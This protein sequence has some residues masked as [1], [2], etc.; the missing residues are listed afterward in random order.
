MAGV[1][2][3]FRGKDQGVA[4]VIERL[5]R[6]AEAQEKKLRE[7]GAAARQ[8]GNDQKAM[9]REAQKVL[10]QIA[11]PQERYNK[12]IE[13]LTKLLQ[14][15][16][17]EQTQFARATQLAKSEMDAST[18]AIAAHQQKMRELSPEA[19]KA[20]AAEKELGDSAK[21]WLA[22]VATPQQ[23]YNTKVAE[24]NKLLAAGKLNQDQYGRAVALAR[25]EM[26]QAGKAGN[27]AFGPGALAM[28]QSFA[29]AFGMAGGLAGAIALA[30][31]E[32]ENLINVQQQAA[33]IS[34][35]IAQAQE[36]ALTNLGADTK[37]Q[38][39]K[40]IQRVK[41]M[42]RELGV[43]ERDVYIRAGEALSARGDQSEDAAMAAVRASFKYSPGDAMAGQAAAG[44]ALDIGRLTGGTAEQ[45]LGFLREIGKQSRVT[46]PRKVAQ[47]LPPAMQAAMATG[48]TQEEAG[49]LWAAL[50]HGMTDTTGERSRTTAISFATQLRDFLPEMK[51][52]DERLRAVQQDPQLREQFLEKTSFE[53][54]AKIPVEEIVSGG[55]LAQTMQQFED[56]LPGLDEA[57]R[58]FN[59]YVA[60]RRSAQLQRLADLDRRAKAS[61]EGL[62]MA[63]PVK[64]QLG[65]IRENFKDTLAQAGL[66]AIG[67]KLAGLT[68]DARG[69]GI[70]EFADELEKQRQ[71]L[72]R[73]EVKG[74]VVG[75]LGLEMAGAARMNGP[76]FRAPTEVEQDQAAVLGL[77]IDELRALAESN[78]QAQQVPQAPPQ[79][80]LLPGPAAGQAAKATPAAARAAQR[81]RDPNYMAPVK[82]MMDQY[83]KAGLLPKG[84][85]PTD[86]AAIGG[87]G[88]TGM[89]AGLLGGA[90]MGGMDAGPAPESDAML[91]F[92]RRAAERTAADLAHQQARVSAAKAKDAGPAPES[93]AMMD[94]HRRA[95]DRTATDLAQ[96][97]DRVERARFQRLKD[98]AMPDLAEFGA[99]LPAAPNQANR[100][101]SPVAESPFA[102]PEGWGEASPAEAPSWGGLD[103][104]KMGRSVRPTAAAGLSPEMQDFA[105]KGGGMSSSPRTAATVEAPAAAQPTINVNVDNKE[106]R[107]LVDAMIDRMDRLIAGN[108]QRLDQLADKFAQ[109]QRRPTLVPPGMDR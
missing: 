13:H 95:A 52:F 83:E 17:L 41:D 8:S 39:D 31:A 65:V 50:T 72:E 103:I 4:A 57:E 47:S 9:G 14:A 66:P 10:D 42:A 106:L 105:S 2:L 45:S 61:V 78:K 11:T 36:T 85:A 64:A 76:V 81:A 15:G 25:S 44:A 63:D 94:F 40:F 6:L 67:Q 35:P 77:L 79:V 99:R 92:H 23:Q 60:D 53:Q 38:Q 5:N 18:A 32:Y 97:K 109:S 54:G 16:K 51:T 88:M 59:K 46:D 68:A 27:E 33:A 62:A 82:S 74:S 70:E 102:R 69:G 56:T 90:M 100:G 7:M 93:K 58:R 26:D 21:R 34:M 48:A 22:Q 71:R 1:D 96:Q 43:S 101:D 12:Q 80:Q 75:G 73:P 89:A 84:A 30:R 86:Q 3:E 49:A 28:V 98:K 104:S 29:G 37:E 87:V 55:K 108:H 24:L 19:R 107:G 20:A 91:D